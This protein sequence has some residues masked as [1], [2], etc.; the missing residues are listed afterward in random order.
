MNHFSIKSIP[1]AYICGLVFLLAA[2]SAISSPTNAVN[3][4]SVTMSAG[5]SVSPYPTTPTPSSTSLSLP[6]G[7][8]A[9]TTKN[10]PSPSPTSF[11]PIVYSG[12][13]S[14]TNANFIRALLIDR[15]G[16]LWS[17]GSGGVVHWDVK[18]GSY[19]KYTAEHG[20]AGNFVTAIAQTPDGALWFGTYGSGISR[21]D[22]VTWKTYTVRD[23]L[24]GDYIVSLLTSPDGT[25][26]AD[27]EPDFETEKGG[28]LAHYDGQTW[29]PSEGGRFDVM[30]VGPDGTLWGGKYGH[31]SYSNGGLWH[32]I[33][34]EWD[35][36]QDLPDKDVT[37]LAV[38]PDGTLWV[39]T[40][41]AVFRYDGNNWE[42]FTPWQGQ[43][44]DAKVVSIAAAPDGTI[45]L[46]FCRVIRGAM[47]IDR[48]E[49]DQLPRTLIAPAGVYRLQQG[50]W[51]LITTQDGLVSN[52]IR[53]IAVTADGSVW[54]GSYD[55]GI[56]H[57]DGE[58]WTTLQ[59]QDVPPY[60]SIISMDISDSGAIWLG[61]T[62]GASFFDG[63]KWSYYSQIGQLEDNNINVINI[64]P[65]QSVWF[66]TPDGVAH[67]DGSSWT[68][69]S[70]S[71][72]EWLDFIFDIA[73]LPD[74][75]HLFT[76]SYGVAEFD[77]HR[78]RV[79]KEFNA[80][81]VTNVLVHP[82]GYWWF[83]ADGDGVY[84]YNGHDWTHYTVETTSSGLA[85][86]YIS[87]I[88]VGPDNKLWLGSCEGISRFDGSTWN[89]DKRPA[90]L[91]GCVGQ[92]IITDSGLVWASAER[93]LLRFSNQSWEQVPYEGMAYRTPGVI[94]IDLD[95]A[96]WIATRAGLSRYLPQSAP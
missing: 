16:N 30:A 66:G 79:F 93:G 70:A 47:N 34:N 36:I 42:G 32:F 39:G 86:N 95:G 52:E 84:A 5:V 65:D 81:I 75:R 24:P 69:Y 25:L 56:S 82:D 15:E 19:V 76:G 73:R 53:A 80:R 85:S 1:I 62:Q 13:K 20:L 45:L 83:V 31:P 26:W 72:Y 71:E 35:Y 55:K 23:G 63:E 87:S 94:A 57:F 40:E 51:S 9:P 12:W 33:G 68:T 48:E 67:F 44:T 49:I 27:I 60:N 90:E 11:P 59:T 29:I 28:G 64:D 4:T 92:M 54:F 58:N 61:Y 22:G 74:G 91:S 17:G 6:T 10:T 21:F 37:A 7:T 3:T 41:T 96:I 77:G 8:S 38:A 14:F 46:G 2:C 18:T 50:E 88:A 43:E 89:T 78:W